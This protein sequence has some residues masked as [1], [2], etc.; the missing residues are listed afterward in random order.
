VCR[1]AE[2]SIV[3]LADKEK[4]GE[5]VVPYINRLSSLLFV[6][7]RLANKHA[8]VKDAEWKI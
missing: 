8:N 5:Q 2:R 3:A 1:R 4:V 7:A 6:L